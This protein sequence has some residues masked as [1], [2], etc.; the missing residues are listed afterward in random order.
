MTSM[1]LGP[2]GELPLWR[3]IT[4][5]QKSM[6]HSPFSVGRVASSARPQ[7]WG[8]LLCSVAPHL[9]AGACNFGRERGGSCLDQGR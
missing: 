1:S 2:S 7:G 4:P 3:R 9:T 8:A 5:G 6:A